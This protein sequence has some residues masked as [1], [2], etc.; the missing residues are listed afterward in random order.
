MKRSLSILLS[1]VITCSSFFV[2]A[3][4]S[5]TKT[6]ALFEDI[7]STRSYYVDFGDVFHEEEGAPFRDVKCYLKVCETENGKED[8]KVA[9]TAKLWF[10]NV[11]L[12]ISEGTIYVYLPFFSINLGKIMGSDSNL[13]YELYYDYIAPLFNSFDSSFVYCMKLNSSGE[14][15]TEEYGKVYVEEFAPDIKKTLEYAEENG[16]IDIA[17]D[18]ELADMTEE[19]LINLLKSFGDKGENVLRMFESNAAFYYRGD[20]LIGYKVT[21]YDAANDNAV[22]NSEDLMIKRAESIGSNVQDSVFDAPF[23]LFDITS[24]ISWIFD[25][26]F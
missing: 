6:E 24:L 23:V 25:I 8:L 19:E 2:T 18:S 3:L 10:F 21:L 12:V 7:K 14:K 9:V 4:A 15:D 11:K 16:L 20:N 22:L 17:D 13:F 26:R 5:E 1:I